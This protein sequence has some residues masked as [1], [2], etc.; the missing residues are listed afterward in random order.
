LFKFSRIQ[1]VLITLLVT[2]HSGRRFTQL[3]PARIYMLVQIQA[4]ENLTV[5]K[6]WHMPNTVNSCYSIDL[7]I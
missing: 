5:N 3:T 1:N 4:Y 2:N 7:D 6:T